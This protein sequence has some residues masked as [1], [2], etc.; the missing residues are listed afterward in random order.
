MTSIPLLWEKKKSTEVSFLPFDNH[1]FTLPLLSLFI[2]FPLFPLLGCSSVTHSHLLCDA[3]AGVR[4][5]HFVCHCAPW[6]RLHDACSCS[7][8]IFSQLNFKV[9]LLD[10][11]HTAFNNWLGHLSLCVEWWPDT[12]WTPDTTLCQNCLWQIQISKD[13][14]QRWVVDEDWKEEIEVEFAGA[15]SLMDPKRLATTNRF[16]LRNKQL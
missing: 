9:L 13:V 1:M 14:L 2:C 4:H 7:S 6:G 12:R 15:Q 3:A 5:T 10:M 16:W 11:H 8:F